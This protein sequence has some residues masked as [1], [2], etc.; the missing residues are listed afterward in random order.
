VITPFKAIKKAILEALNDVDWSK[1]VGFGFPIPKKGEVHKWCKEHIGTV[2]TFQGKQENTVVFVLGA[3]ELNLGSAQW[4]S[5]RPNLLK[6]A[7][8]RAQRRFFIVG[9]KSLWGKMSYFSEVATSRELSCRTPEEFLNAV[10]RG[11]SFR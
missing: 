7:I 3:D 6:V 8:T 1:D 2:H 4:A 5:C 9:D 10:F 11:P